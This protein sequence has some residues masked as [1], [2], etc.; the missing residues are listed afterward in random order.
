[1]RRSLSSWLEK[2]DVADPPRDDLVFAT[3][4]AAANAI[5]YGTPKRPFEVRGSVVDRVVTMAISNEGRWNEVRR[6]NDERG[7]GLALIEAMVMK[8]EIETDPSG[9]TVRLVQNF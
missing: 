8:M 9:T 2:A 4:E 3:H 1:M 7:R 6:E 5:E